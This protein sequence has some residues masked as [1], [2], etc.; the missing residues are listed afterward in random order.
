VELRVL[1]CKLKAGSPELA[2]FQHEF[3]TLGNLDHPNIIRVLDLGV[4]AD[5]V[6]YVTDL[7]NAKP[8]LELMDKGR[9]FTFDEAI[10]ICRQVLAAVG[11]LH[12]KRVVHRDLSSSTIFLDLDNNIPYIAEFSLVKNF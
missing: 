8:F 9:E 2:R 12:R 4:M 6:F 11:H 10:T 3:S 7:R 1:N 5:H